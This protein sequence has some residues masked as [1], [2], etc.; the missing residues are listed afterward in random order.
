VGVESTSLGNVLDNTQ[1][2]T[3]YLFSADSG[4]MSECSGACANNWPPLQAP[5]KPTS[6]DG[7]KTSFISTT[8]RTGGTRQVTY[9]G[10]P[11]YLFKGDSKPGE[12][13]GEGVN[14]FGG[15]WYAVSPGGSRVVQTSNSGSGGGGGGG[16]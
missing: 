11:L 6:A 8:P 10:H 3:L 4:T 5:A 9:K 2:R 16:Y 7:A 14:A 15:N 13:N 1:G 12:T